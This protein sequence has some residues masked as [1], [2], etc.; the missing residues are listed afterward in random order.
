MSSG[1]TPPS[2][3]STPA[4]VQLSRPASREFVPPTRNVSKISLPPSLRMEMSLEPPA[5]LL[6]SSSSPSLLFTN[7][8]KLSTSSKKL[9]T[10]SKK[11]PTLLHR[12]STLE[13]SGAKQCFPSPIINQ[14]NESMKL[15]YKIVFVKIRDKRSRNVLECLK[16]VTE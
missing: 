7:S 6:A 10:N 3:T 9:S 15:S 16:S 14:T 12:F 5:S 11:L 4:S 1:G 2:K 13:D 8:R